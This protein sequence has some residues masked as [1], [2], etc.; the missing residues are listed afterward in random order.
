[1]FMGFFAKFRIFIDVASN[2]KCI[3]QWMP[4][5]IPSTTYIQQEPIRSVPH[6]KILSPPMKV[7]HHE[8]YSSTEVIG[9]LQQDNILR[10][11]LDQAYGTYSS[12]N[13]RPPSTFNR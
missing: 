7:L 10:R 3:G 11:E 13:Y 9:M 5:I 8:V 6:P 12:R 2:G 1:M 4:D